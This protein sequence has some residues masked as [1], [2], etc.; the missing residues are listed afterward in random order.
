MLCSLKFNC[1]KKMQNFLNLK[2]IYSN[3]NEIQGINIDEKSS[4][5]LTFLYDFCF[6]EIP[7]N[8]E[9]LYRKVIFFFK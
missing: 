1:Q 8:Q 4:M 2:F 6:K 9:Y 5:A 7:K 3:R